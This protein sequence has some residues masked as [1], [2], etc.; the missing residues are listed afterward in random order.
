MLEDKVARVDPWA[1][2]VAKAAKIVFL[3]ALK[4][5]GIDEKGQLILAAV[6]KSR[7]VRGEYVLGYYSYMTQFRGRARIVVDP[8]AIRSEL[9]PSLCGK[10]LTLAIN[11]QVL[12]T[13]AHEYGHVIAEFLRVTKRGA[14]SNIWPCAKIDVPD[15]TLSFTDEEDFAE[16]FAQYLTKSG[17]FY[18]DEFWD[19]FL[20]KYVSA[21][22]PMYS[23]EGFRQHYV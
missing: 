16:D 11:E 9:A 17:D 5:H 21:V 14:L 7:K 3:A 8:V 6:R 15:W 18:N 13:A 20:P 23:S 10:A 19:T 2:K 4:E 1:Q 12:M 22:A